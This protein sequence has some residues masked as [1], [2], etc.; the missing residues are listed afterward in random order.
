MS[1]RWKVFIAPFMLCAMLG[2]EPSFAAGALAVGV[3]PDVA[4]QGFASGFIINVPTMD[5][6]R[7][8]AVEGCHKSVGASE[9]AKKLCTVVATFTNQCFAI[10]IDPKAGTPGAG[11]AIAEDQKNADAQALAQCRSTAGASRRQFCV[12]PEGPGMGTNRGCDGTAK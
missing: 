8:G 5:R 7:E 9:P 4:R 3:P 6:A 11:W 12:I 2:S 10:A 1:Y